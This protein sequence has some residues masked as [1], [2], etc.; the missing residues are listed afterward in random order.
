M[1]F[2]HEN[3]PHEL[4]NL[5]GDPSFAEIIADLQQRLRNSAIAAK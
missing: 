4:R 3:D 5:A 1:L 2:D